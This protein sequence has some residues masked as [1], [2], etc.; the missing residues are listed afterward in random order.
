MRLIQATSRRVSARVDQQVVRSS[1]LSASWQRPGS[2]RITRVCVGRASSTIRPVT[3]NAIRIA[4][5][6][7]PTVA[8]PSWSRARVTW[9]YSGRMV[10]YSRD[11]TGDT[12]VGTCV[13]ATATFPLWRLFC[14]L[15]PSGQALDRVTPVT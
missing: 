15:P 10:R 11:A 12:S 6:G 8:T 5:V 3:Y 4:V 2:K 9:R 7:L 13:L 1:R 14:S